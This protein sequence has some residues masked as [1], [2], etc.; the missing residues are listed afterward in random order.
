MSD[1]EA[2]MEWLTPEQDFVGA[3]LASCRQCSR[4]CQQ[5][6]RD[7]LE[8]GSLYAEAGHVTQLLSCA[9]V[10]RTTAELIVIDSDWYPTLADLCAH[11]CVE[12]ADACDALDDMDECAEAC[13]DCAH[14]CRRLV[15]AMSV[16]ESYGAQPN[17]HRIPQTI[18]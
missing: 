9:Q 13:R 1:T 12:C 7:G 3:C 11:V 18:N 15:T 8:P 10:C 14:A 5:R 17:E 16:D 2:S 6:V 4:V